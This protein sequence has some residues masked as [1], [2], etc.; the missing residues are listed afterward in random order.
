MRHFR[1]D[2]G[3]KLVETE[4][5]AYIHSAGVTT[6]HSPRDTLQMNSITELWVHSVLVY[7]VAFIT[8]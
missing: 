7:A 5:L 1:L 6:P 8:G 2:G 3:A 4:G